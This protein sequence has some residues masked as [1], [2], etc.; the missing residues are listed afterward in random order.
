[1]RE[2]IQITRDRFVFMATEDN[3]I[4]EVHLLRDYTSSSRNRRWMLCVSY[5]DSTSKS[6]LISNEVA[7]TLMSMGM[8]TEG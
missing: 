1:M 8:D 4:D 6:F 2:E 5:K 3:K 7:N